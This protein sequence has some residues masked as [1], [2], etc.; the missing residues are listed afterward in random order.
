MSIHSQYCL[1]TI[2]KLNALI[3]SS[4]IIPE[5]NNTPTAE[6][7]WFRLPLAHVTFFFSPCH[8]Y[9]ISSLWTSQWM[10]LDLIYSRTHRTVTISWSQCSY[11]QCKTI[12]LPE[13]AALAQWL[14]SPTCSLEAL[15]VACPL[16][17]WI[18][19]GATL[20]QKEHVKL[21]EHCTA[22]LCLRGYT[23]Q[24]INLIGVSDRVAITLADMLRHNKPLKTLDLHY[25]S[26][27]A[28]D[29]QALLQSLQ[30]SDSLSKI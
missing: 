8:H 6:V 17:D 30:H 4:S 18:S 14:S 5:L 11:I 23:S 20:V 26:L 16:S 28:Q 12:G 27:T 19:G 25:T 1:F 29:T 13:C 3:Y 24:I 2:H 21:L 15:C 7:Q 10:A 22:T 9:L